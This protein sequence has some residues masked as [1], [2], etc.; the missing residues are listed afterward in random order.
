MDTLQKAIDELYRAF[1]V[2]EPPQ[3]IVGCPC[4]FDEYEIQKLLETQLR[5]ISPELMAPYAS[6]A[7]LTVGSI[8]DYLYYLPRIL[9]ISIRDESWW[10]AIEVT[11]RAIRGTHIDSWPTVR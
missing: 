8:S 7:L 9:E 3:Q 5:H 6:S 11:G 2:V 4:C 1:E 10:P